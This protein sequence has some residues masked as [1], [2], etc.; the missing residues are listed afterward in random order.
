MKPIIDQAFWADPAIEASDS[1]VKLAALWLMTNSQTSLLGI[2]SASPKRFEFE[3]GLPGAA[4][5][6]A[7]Q[8]LPQ[9]FQRFEGGIFIRGYV[10]QQFGARE[11]LTRNNFFTGL[12]TLFAALRDP[13]LRT[14]F[15]AEYPEF[16]SPPPA[17]PRASEGLSKPKD[18]R[19]RKEKDVQDDAP[20][21]RLAPASSPSV[22]RGASVE[23][24]GSASADAPR[25]AAADP[26][27]PTRDEARAYGRE[28]GMDE[29][30]VDAWFDHFESNGWR[31]GGKTPMKDWPAALRNGSRRQADL[32]A[33]HGAEPGAMKAANPDYLQTE[34][35][36]WLKSRGQPAMEYRCAPEFLKS[37][38][39]QERKAGRP[40]A[41]I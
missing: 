38:F 14:A 2:C 9:L 29:A 32:R 6:A 31:V 20:G 3:T 17:L 11:K 26:R 4:L 23:P 30:E 41:A 37:D 16:D 5:E 7:L 25:A 22:S 34:W 1:S 24:P 28:L 40:V 36:A 15:L 8:A 27:K 10:R 33:R 35:P 13:G 21:E 18:E 19:E 12:K 39:H